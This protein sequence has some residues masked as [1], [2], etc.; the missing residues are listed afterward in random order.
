MLKMGAVQNETQRDL[1]KMTDMVKIWDQN[2]RPNAENGWQN[3]GAQLEVGVGYVR[4]HV[5]YNRQ[6]QG[7]VHNLHMWVKLTHVPTLHNKNYKDVYHMIYDST[8][9]WI[10]MTDDVAPACRI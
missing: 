1:D 10:K 4:F 3:R 9:V 6:R 8:M 7:A 5:L 2:D